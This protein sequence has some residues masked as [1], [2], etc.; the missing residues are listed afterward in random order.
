MNSY[1]VDGMTGVHGIKHRIWGRLV[2][3]PVALTAVAFF[4]CSPHAE[5]TPQFARRHDLRCNA[6]HVI[7]PKLNAYGLAFAARGYRRAPQPEGETVA[8]H[9]FAVWLTGSHEDQDPKGFSETLFPKV[10]IISGGPLGDYLSYFVEW[11]TVSRGTRSD[12]SIRDRS[13]R[14]EDA[15]INWKVD[16]RSSVT[17]GQYRALNQVD[18]SR[19]LSISEPALFSTSLPGESASDKRIESLRAFSPS[20]RSPGLTYSYQSL[21]GES[22]SDGLFHFVTVPFVGE[23]SIPL[24]SKARDAAS[25]ELRGEPKGVLLETFYRK[26]LNSIGLHS[27][28]GDD[29]WLVTGVGT[30]NLDNFYFTGGLGV[31]DRRDGSPRV[32]SSLEL[33]YLYTRDIDDLYRPGVGFRVEHVSNDGRDPAYIPYFVL[34]G[35]NKD[36]T[37]LLQIQ[38]RAQKDNEGFFIHFSMLF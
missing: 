16:E 36:H 7:A 6:C 27:F 14:F 4:V 30:L 29:R 33:E 1:D 15:F 25:F 20:G 19:R 5:A 3:A 35:P 8:T 24:T 23:L 22:P 38:Y 10:E 31:D 34:S 26:G 21:Q 28:I 37:F 2:A 32:R 13:G 9:P 12:G 18:V 17:L 11:R